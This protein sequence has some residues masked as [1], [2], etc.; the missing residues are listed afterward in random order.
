MRWQGGEKGDVSK[1]QRGDTD[2]CE[3]W[4]RAD[5]CPI[6]AYDSEA[7]VHDGVIISIALDFAQ[8]SLRS[9]GSLHR[10][11]HKDS[12]IWGPSITHSDK[13]RTNSDCK[14]GEGTPNRTSNKVLPNLYFN[15]LFTEAPQNWLG[16]PYV[17]F[18]ASD[19][20]MA[21]GMWWTDG[22][23]SAVFWLHKRCLRSSCTLY[24]TRR[25]IHH[26]SI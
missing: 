3:I 14:P 4:N 18:F 23:T 20:C 1:K 10:Q 11:W 15:G 17:C 9:K 6:S 2:T 26:N 22:S 24:C 25:H 19:P 12:Q 13:T 7:W 16:D 5:S 8:Q 21:Q